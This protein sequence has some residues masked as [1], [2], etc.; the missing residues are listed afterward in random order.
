MRS[1]LRWPD[2]LG[3]GRLAFQHAGLAGQAGGQPHLLQVGR[4]PLLVLAADM[5]EPGHHVR[6]CPL[7]FGQ[8]LRRS[9]DDAARPS[10]T[11]CVGVVELLLQIVGPGAQGQ[12]LAAVAGDFLLQIAAA[13]PLVL[14]GRFLAGDPL[15]VGGDPRLR[16]GGWPR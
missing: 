11:A 16:P 3:R 4:P 15:A 10:S 6:Q 1:R 13:G 12:Q 7:A 9:G 5:V 14:D 2:R 8:P